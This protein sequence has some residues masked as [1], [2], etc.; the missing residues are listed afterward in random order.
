MQPLFPPLVVDT[1]A[2]VV[3][4]HAVPVEFPKV[5]GGQV[6]GVDDQPGP[7]RDLVQEPAVVQ[8]LVVGF[9]ELVEA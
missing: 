4:S 3:E 9:D 6:R 8:V 7:V 1:L 2:E 5:A